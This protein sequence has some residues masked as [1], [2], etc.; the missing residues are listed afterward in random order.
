MINKKYTY[1]FVRQDLSQEQQAVQ[2]CHATQC[3]IGLLTLAE[4]N[5]STLVLLGV[6]NRDTLKKAW[7]FIDGQGI[8]TRLFLEPD[9]D[10]EATAFATEPV[11]EE[12]R[13]H[14]ANFKTLRFKKG[15]LH[16]LGVFYR[17]IRKEFSY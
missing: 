1:V 4:A 13:E 10:N 11:K 6:Q 8:K 12:Q 17:S 15:F 2:A 16:H 3:T 5:K 9:K 7:N 14:F